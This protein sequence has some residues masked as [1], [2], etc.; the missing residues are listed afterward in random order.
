[1][2]VTGAP[3]DE[4]ETELR[5]I[6]LRDSQKGRAGIQPVSDYRIKPIETIEIG[7]IAP[8]DHL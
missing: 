8:G 6:L 1:M 4:L 7:E 5:F 3:V 2:L